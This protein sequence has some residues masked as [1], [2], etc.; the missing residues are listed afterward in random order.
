MDDAW[1]DLPMLLTL[2]EAARLLRVGR[3]HAYNQTTLYF[4]TMGLDGIAAIRIGGVIRVPKHALHELITTGRLVQR[5]DHSPA[6]ATAPSVRTRVRRTTDGLFGIDKAHTEGRH[7]R[8]SGVAILKR[9]MPQTNADVAFYE[10][11]FASLPSPPQLMPWTRY[12]GDVGDIGTQVRF[13]WR[14]A[15]TP[16]GG[17]AAL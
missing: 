8:I 3:S 9:G 7:K 17:P 16:T 12:F 2:D 5:I 15:P 13:D 11:P 14:D 4:A 6:R 10:N 1:A